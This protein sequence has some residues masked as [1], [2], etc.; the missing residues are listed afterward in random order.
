MAPNLSDSQKSLAK[1]GEKWYTEN[2]V[3]ISLISMQTVSY[4]ND[5][6]FSAIEA[7]GAVTYAEPQTPDEVVEACRGAQIVLVNK[8]MMDEYVVSRLPELK[9][10]G[11]FATGYNNLD[12]AACKKRGIVCCNAP[13]YSTRSVAQHT[14][15][16]I[17]S[18]AGS[19]PL[20]FQSV[21][22]GDWTK[23][24]EFTYYTYPTFEVYHSVLGIIGYGSIG[25]RV[26][27]IA[28]AMG[29][30]IL[31]NNR[32]RVDDPDV[33]QVG[34]EEIFRRSDF[35]SLHCPL[36]EETKE[37]VNAETL[38]FMKPSAAV[39]NTARG[40]LIN[41]TDIAE[42]LQAGRLRCLYADTVAEEPMRRDNPLYRL[43][44]CFISPHTAWLATKT[45][46]ELVSI[47]AA[48]LRAY[49]NGSPQNVIV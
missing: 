6:D 20:Y 47:V 34:L 3:K 19:L 24:K 10:I 17:L 45:R 31:V 4:N 22:R 11:V 15:G 13:G 29:M 39:I 43:D 33:E 2:M 1:R 35:L 9:Y 41:E 49:L 32:S 12:L 18:A 28:K 21:K 44:N 23:V 5:I 8:T 26:A 42:A 7:L 46:Q 38:R 37:I 16:M 25:R 40:G 14:M 48:N 27:Q 36:N 30:K